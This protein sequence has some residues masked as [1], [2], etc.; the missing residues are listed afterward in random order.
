MSDCLFCKFVNG[1]IKP[2]KVYEDDEL[3]AFRDIS[4]QAP[5]HILV[6]PKR[7]ISTL[8]DLE[9][10]DEA[11]MGKLILAAQ[12]VAKEEGIDE[13]GYRT[14]INCNEDAGQSVFHI[15]LHLLGGR[16]MKWPPG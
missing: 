11:L 7:H 15:H 6:I 14:V 16:H 3:L 8:N 2:D 4:P 1:E 9:S 5:I 13:V 10:D 12:R